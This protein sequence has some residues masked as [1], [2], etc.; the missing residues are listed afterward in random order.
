[1]TTI[2]RYADDTPQISKILA[3][4]T[5]EQI[6]IAYDQD[7]DGICLLKKAYFNSP[8]STNIAVEITTG[9]IADMKLFDGYLYVLLN[10]DSRVFIVYGENNPY[11]DVDEATK[12]YGIP[13]PVGITANNNGILVLLPGSTSGTNAKVMVY[14]LGGTYQSIIDLPGVYDAT[15]IISD[16][17]DNAWIVTNTNPAKLIRVWF[18]SGGWYKQIRSITTPTLTNAMQIISYDSNPLFAIGNTTPFQI[19]RIG[20]TGPDSP[21]WTVSTFTGATTPRAIAINT[22]AGYLYVACQDGLITKVNL[23]NLAPRCG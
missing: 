11:T 17:S 12:P 7:S 5:Q 16:S 4:T 20:V 13:E 14:S 3:S 21:T 19:A 18:A 1:M 23:S 2:R 6:W 8:E 10:G 15:S 22:T 9:A